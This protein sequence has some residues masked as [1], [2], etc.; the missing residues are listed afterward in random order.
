MKRNNNYMFQSRK[1]Q[2]GKALMISLLIS[3][4]IMTG[5]VVWIGLNDWNVEKSFKK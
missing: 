3:G 4:I 2:K 1:K 5:L